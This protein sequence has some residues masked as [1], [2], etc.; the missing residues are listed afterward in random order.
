MDKAKK[1]A[2]AALSALAS[3]L[4]AEWELSDAIIVEAMIVQISNMGAGDEPALQ[5]AA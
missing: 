4:Y 5:E 3:A 1:D 2:I